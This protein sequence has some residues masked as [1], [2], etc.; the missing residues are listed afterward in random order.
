MLLNEN[1][2]ADMSKILEHYHQQYVPTLDAEGHH[3]L[4]DGGE[5]TFDDTQFFTIFLGGDQ[6]TVAR[7]RGAKALRASHNT[8]HDRLEGI[9]PVVEDW[10]TRMTLM[11]VSYSLKLY[12]S[13]N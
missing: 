3:T 10:H 9:I 12:F 2:V 6:L 4:P 8:P 13:F 7:A 11:R 5:L 1:K